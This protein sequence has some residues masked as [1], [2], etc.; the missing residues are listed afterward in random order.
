MCKIR[1]EAVTHI[2]SEYSKLAQTNYKARHERV[3]SAVHWSIIKALGLL[4]PKSWY[5]HRADK[6]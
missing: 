2:F 4:H 1:D 3:A 6:V 5:E